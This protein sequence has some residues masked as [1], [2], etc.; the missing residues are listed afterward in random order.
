MSEVYLG[1]YLV[2]SDWMGQQTY[3]RGFVDQKMCTKCISQGRQE[4]NYHPL[5]TV[6]SDIYFTMSGWE[7]GMSGWEGGMS[8]WEG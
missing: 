2:L 4:K 7:G 5:I 3:S 6:S 8:G 1:R